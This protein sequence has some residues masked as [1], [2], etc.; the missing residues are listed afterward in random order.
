M[1]TDENMTEGDPIESLDLAALGGFE[2]EL[3][4]KWPRA[5]MLAHGENSHQRAAVYGPV[6]DYFKQC[7]GPFPGFTAIQDL[8]AG[9]FLMGEFEKA[10]VAV[11][12][13]GHIVGVMVALSVEDAWSQWPAGSRVPEAVVVLNRTVDASFLEQLSVAGARV[14]LAPGYTMDAIEWA[15]QGAPQVSLLEMTQ[16]LRAESLLDIRL[17]PFGALVQDRERFSMSLSAFRLEPGVLIPPCVLEDVLFAA[18]CAKHM[19]SCGVVIAH[20]ET[21]LAI[22]TGQLSGRDAW[23]LAR[24][25]AK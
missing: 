2:P 24:E 21:T 17:L 12:K 14:L 1:H 13:Q 23:L 15:A 22:S 11:I 18:R 5:Q 3:C 7:A 25:R 4:L 6:A 8:V 20:K 16:L 19:R 10:A 9:M